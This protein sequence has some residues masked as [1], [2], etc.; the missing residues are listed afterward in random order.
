MGVHVKGRG[1]RTVER[2][3]LSLLLPPAACGQDGG[4]AAL[5]VPHAVHRLDA[6]VGGLLLVAKTRRAEVALSAQLE[7]HAVAKRYRAILAGRADRLASHA[8]VRPLGSASQGGSPAI[9]IPSELAELKQVRNGQEGEVLVV[10]GEIDGRPCATAMRL[11][12]CT[13]RCVVLERGPRV[14]G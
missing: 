3:L 5:P 2:A 6:R 10:R 4:D 13:R 12:S 1:Q 9:A 7:R 14:A 8:S 11:V